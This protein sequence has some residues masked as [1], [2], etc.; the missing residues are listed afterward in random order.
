MKSFVHLFKGGRGR[1]SP[2][3]TVQRLTEPAGE[4]GTE[5]PRPL[6]R[7]SRDRCEPGAA[8]A[9]APRA[10][11]QRLPPRGRKIP[12]GFA[13]RDFGWVFHSFSK[14]TPASPAGGESYML[15]TPLWEPP[16]SLQRSATERAFWP[17]GFKGEPRLASPYGGGVIALAM[18]EGE[19]LHRGP[20][21]R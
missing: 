12:L 20:R 21:G 7:R 17:Q 2:V 4:K 14:P 8:A 6:E 19:A 10:I 16:R 13:R 1:W 11:G 5:S 15:P 9:R 18:T 3:A